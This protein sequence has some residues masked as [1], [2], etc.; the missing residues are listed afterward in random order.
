MLVL[1]ID[2]CASS[3]G[4][5]VWLDGSWLFRSKEEM[6]RGQDARLLPMIM[7]AMGG[8]N[9]SFS[10]ID[11]IAVMRGPGSFTGVRVCLA[12]ARGIGL[13]LGKPVLGV[14]RFSVYGNMYS[15]EKA[16]LVAIESRRAEK[17]CKY[18]P[19]SGDAHEAC[20]MTV[21]EI[22][23]F[24]KSNPDVRMVGDMTAKEEDDLAACVEIAVRADISD[25]DFA[26]RPLY[27]RLPDVTI[28]KA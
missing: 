6:S 19:S 12:A 21:E 22:D 25:P 8:A 9:K 3:C 18:Y 4:V 14:D 1:A 24:L 23:R 11:R 13:T 16:L 27:I 10:D 15:D 20:M 17:F 7:E 5:G 28:S 26:P 2:S